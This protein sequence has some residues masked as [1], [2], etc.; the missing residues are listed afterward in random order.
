[1]RH[2]PDVSDLAATPLFAD[3]DPAELAPIA[4]HVDRLVVLPGATVAEEGRHPH[5]VVVIVSGEVSELRDGIEAARRGAGTV[6]GAREELDGTA[7]GATVVAC[8]AVDA[9]VITGAA[10]R[11]AVQSLPGFTAPRGASV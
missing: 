3:F 7:H 2:G 5:E 4:P 6:I 10:Y 11:W 8:T 1:M 9:L